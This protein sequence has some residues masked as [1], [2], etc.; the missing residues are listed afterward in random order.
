[1]G[2]RIG[3]LVAILCFLLLPSTTTAQS[4]IDDFNQI[5][6]REALYEDTS[7]PRVYTIC[8][9]HIFDVGNLDFNGNLIQPISGP[10]NPPIPLRANMTLKCGD[11]GLRENRCWI[12][13]GDLHVDGTKVLGISDDTIENVVLEGFVF[14]GARDHALL[15]NKPGSI[16]FRDCEFREFVQSSVPIMLDYYDASNPSTELVAT[17]VD[18]DFRDNRYFGMSSQSALI[19]GNSNQN[20]IEIDSVIFQNN[21][22]IWNNTKPD[23]HSYIVE[24][25]GPVNMRKTCFIDN[26]VGASDVVVF[27]STFNN[28]LNFAKN[29]SGSLCPFLSVFDTTAQ[30][31]T[32]TPTCVDTSTTECDR[33]VTPSPTASPSASPT[34]SPAPSSA[35]TSLPSISPRPTISPMPTNSPTTPTG[36]P[37]DEP[38]ESPSKLELDFFWP[39]IMTEAPVSAAPLSSPA[40][41]MLLLLCSAGM[42]CFFLA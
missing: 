14:I 4:C 23:T 10:V 38:S 2:P 17:F 18:C 25:L 37:T 39:T 13:G 41:T 27:G 40:N 12:R 21:D 31:Q 9:R 6:T 5:Y 16:T 34:I 22:M 35:P 7:F 19:Y 33:F 15:A 11:Q 32:F 30:F 8:P 36:M 26:L 24:S 28:E 3:F 29:S 1:M 42:Y 20:R